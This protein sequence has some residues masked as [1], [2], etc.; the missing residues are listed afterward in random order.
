MANNAA[1]KAG[2]YSK[3]FTSA[4]GD[5]L[6]SVAD[7]A[8]ET[9]E[10][11]GASAQKM[12]NG[13]LTTPTSG[14]QS[15]VRLLFFLAGLAL[16]LFI[17]LVGIHYTVTPVFSFMPGD[18]GIIPIATPGDK[19]IAF[20]GAIATQN[21]SCNFADLKTMNVAFAFDLF[22]TSDFTT[23]IPRV[24]WY[25][26]TNPIALQSGDTEAGLGAKYPSSN[27]V[28]YVDP[29]KNDLK[30]LIQTKDS[31]S[32]TVTA[33]Q[34][35][36]FENLPI[37]QPVRIGMVIFKNFVEIYINGSLVHTTVGLS[38]LL[39]DE[40]P[41]LNVF[42]PP[43]AVSGSVKVSRITYWPYVISPKMFRVDAADTGSLFKFA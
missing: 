36:V 28:L 27:V 12:A 23:P 40:A 39:N 13:L 34:E 33:T 35:T 32:A 43:T 11:I 21:E 37:R 16:F 24:I 1:G 26:S 14:F 38:D 18:Q 15:G 30:V 2:I 10:S 19:Q 7:K 20:P 31:A 22:I 42:G 9:A 5:A 8:T 17:F 3:E 41:N 4:V 6:N 25:K 29:L